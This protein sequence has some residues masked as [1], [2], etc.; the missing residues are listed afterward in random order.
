MLV[1][2][3]PTHWVKMF[4]II[5]E[6]KIQSLGNVWIVTNEL[7]NLHPQFLLRDHF[8]PSIV[9]ILSETM[10]RKTT[11]KKLMCYWTIHHCCIIIF[12]LLLSMVFL[13]FGSRCYGSTVE[14]NPTNCGMSGERY[15]GNRTMFETNV[16]IRDYYWGKIGLVMKVLDEYSITGAETRI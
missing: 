7:F 16:K 1:V 9:I 14:E 11:H 13:A 2:N 3:R 6:I 4:Q 5:T 8:V 12:H 15:P 10:V